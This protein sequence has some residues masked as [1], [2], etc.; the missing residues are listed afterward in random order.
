MTSI[1]VWT[2]LDLYLKE[3]LL[4]KT[5]DFDIIQWWQHAGVK[6]PTLCKIVRDVLAI[7]VTMVASKSM[8]VLVGGSLVH[9]VLGLRLQ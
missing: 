8:L 1:Y 4:S 9:I 3:P 2:K 5:Q 6:Y 7:L